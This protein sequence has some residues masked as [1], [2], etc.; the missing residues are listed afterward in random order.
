MHVVGNILRLLLRVIT[1]ALGIALVV[2]ILV[3]GLWY[4]WQ[5]ARGQ[6]PQVGYTITAQK[7]EKTA[8]GLY[9][10]YKGDVVTR[11]AR[12]GDE[13]EV[14]FVVESSEGVGTVAY[15]LE[16]LGLV[17]DG[18]VFRRVV[19][20]NEADGDIEAGVY[21][22][23]AG[24]TMEQIMRQLQHGR[25]P[26]VA[27]TLPEGWR[28]EEMAAQLETLGVITPA[29]SFV[30]AVNRGAGA[31]EYMR[32]RPGGAP[33]GLEGFLFPDT[34]QM[35][36]DAAPE[37]VIEIML[38][39]WDRYVPEELRAKAAERK[40]TL[41]EVVTL[42]SIVEREAVVASE[43][44]LIAGV[45][46]NRLKQGMYLQADPTVQYAKGYNPATKKWWNPTLQ[47]ES[48][49]VQSPYNT[50]LR[51]GLPPGPICNPGQASIKA[52]LAPQP[53]EFLFFYAKGDGSHA[54]AKTYEEHLRNQQLYVGKL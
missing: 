40:L 42:A 24:M 43:R 12:P 36:R 3:G 10:R 49:T 31:P 4:V 15:N 9:L 5:D 47:E 38:Q 29:L 41:Y 17:A 27:V 32:V 45:Y 25:L 22:L 46:L 8:L 52:V 44:P 11:P 35:P 1:L 2:F 53:S 20:Y 23:K 14:P 30:E 37:R 18:E 51:G 54:F 21:T 6:A 28:V 50:Y 7:V 34:Y 48:Q 26:S 39:N 16:R 33:G 13:R 19:Q